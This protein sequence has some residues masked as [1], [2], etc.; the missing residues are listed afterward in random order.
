MRE[1]SRYMV[2]VAA[3]TVALVWSTMQEPPRVETVARPLPTIASTLG[4]TS[5]QN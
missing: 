5:V 4:A 3:M 2:A 1:I